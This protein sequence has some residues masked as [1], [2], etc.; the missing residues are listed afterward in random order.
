MIGETLSA[1]FEII[2]EQGDGVTGLS[3]STIASTDPLGAAFTV[4]Y[5]E[6]GGGAYFVIADDVAAMAGTYTLFVDANDSIDPGQTQKFRI[7]WDVDAVS[8]VVSGIQ[9]IQYVVVPHPADPDGTH[10]TRYYTKAEGEDALES[11]VEGLATTGYVDDGLALKADQADLSQLAEDVG[12]ILIDTDDMA[13][14]TWVTGELAGYSPT[15][16]DHNATYYQ[17]S[18]SDAQLAAKVNDFTQGY[19]VTI[20]LGNGVDLITAS[21]LPVD[22]SLPEACTLVGA[23]LWSDVSGTI[24]LGSSKAASG[25]LSFTNIHASAPLKLGNP[26]AQQIATPSLTGWTTSFDQWDKVRTVVS[27]NATGI[28][29]VRICYRFQKGRG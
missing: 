10:D 2:D 17:K 7:W 16:H 18:E 1:Q 15:S 11:L 23:E 12:E 14:E 20:T 28:K 25:S 3:P 5:S 4:A 13:T 21:E 27:V 9:R 19:A 8:A 22:F 26:S 29:L 6:I 24:T